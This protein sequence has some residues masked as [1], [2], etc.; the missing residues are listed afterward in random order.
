[1]TPPVRSLIG[2]IA[3]ICCLHSCNRAGTP[4]SMEAKIWW[5]TL[6]VWQLMLSRSMLHWEMMHQPVWDNGRKTCCCCWL[7]SPFYLSF[8]RSWYEQSNVAW[9]LSGVYHKLFMTYFSAAI[10]ANVPDDLCSL[11]PPLSGMLTVQLLWSG[12]YICLLYFT[13]IKLKYFLF[14][15]YREKAVIL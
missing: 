1:M 13:N 8:Y 14:P 4:F 7:S 12:L 11:S 10:F 15:L 6:I 9:K 3:T 5:L 2:A